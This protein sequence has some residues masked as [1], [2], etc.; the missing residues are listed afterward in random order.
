MTNIYAEQPTLEKFHVMNRSFTIYDELQLARDEAARI[1]N[2]RELSLLEDVISKKSGDDDF[3]EFIGIFIPPVLTTLLEKHVQMN[4]PLEPEILTM[5]EYMETLFRQIVNGRE[6]FFLLLSRYTIGAI[7]GMLSQV[8]RQL[9]GDLAR[10]HELQYIITLIQSLYEQCLFESPRLALVM[11]KRLQD[12]H[13]LDSWYLDRFKKYHSLLTSILEQLYLDERST[14]EVLTNCLSKWDENT[15]YQTIADTI[16][17]NHYLSE[18]LNNFCRKNHL[19]RAAVEFSLLSI[20]KELSRRDV[21]PRTIRYVN[22][23]L[24]SR[25]RMNLIKDHLPL[26]LFPIVPKKIL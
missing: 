18:V 24:V 22:L 6:Q 23:F 16:Q 7:F 13:E 26:T 1:V 3:K 2:S 17:S 25:Q 19:T 20:L 8:L 15:I 14:S 9:E 21:D 4:T 12:I 10:E 11:E 5:M